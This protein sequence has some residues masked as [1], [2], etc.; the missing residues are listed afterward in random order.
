MRAATVD[1]HPGRQPRG[2]AHQQATGAMIRTAPAEPKARR[3]AERTTAHATGD[4]LATREDARACDAR[5]T[6]HGRSSM[7][8]LR[9]KIRPGMRRWKI[10]GPPLIKSVDF[11]SSQRA[12]DH[13]AAEPLVPV[14][15]G[16]I[17]IDA[18]HR[19][20]FSHTHPIHPPLSRA[21]A[22]P[23]TSPPPLLPELRRLPRPFIAW[24]PSVACR[25]LARRRRTRIA[26]APAR[27]PRRESTSRRDR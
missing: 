9:I 24:S 25:H 2:G 22:A 1:A 16:P 18:Q 3:E 10:S 23:G 13:N 20:F 7:T 14:E 8:Q 27:P 17:L 19:A 12:Y 15:T 26:W 5:R 21:Y 4:R 6:T 11:D